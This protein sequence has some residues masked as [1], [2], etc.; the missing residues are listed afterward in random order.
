MLHITFTHMVS[1]ESLNYG[2]ATADVA[3][4]FGGSLLGEFTDDLGMSESIV[5][6]LQSIITTIS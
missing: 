1:N 5:K 2:S 6:T 4:I 3:A